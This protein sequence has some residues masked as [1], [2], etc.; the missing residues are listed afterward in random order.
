MTAFLPAQLRSVDLNSV[1]GATLDHK[2][3][4][5]EPLHPY[6]LNPPDGGGHEPCIC[7]INTIR[8]KW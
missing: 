2:P 5:P 4:S 7:R 8:P 1:T 6:Q 3:N